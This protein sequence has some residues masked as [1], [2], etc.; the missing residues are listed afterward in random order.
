MRVRC[1]SI[2]YS[3]AQ[4]ERVRVHV[5]SMFALFVILNIIYCS[6]LARYEHTTSGSV[7]RMVVELCSGLL[8]YEILLMSFVHLVVVCMIAITSLLQLLA[9]QRLHAGCSYRCCCCYYRYY[10]YCYCYHRSGCCFLYLY[11]VPFFLNPWL[12]FRTKF[13]ESDRI[14]LDRQKKTFLTIAID[15]EADAWACGCLQKATEPSELPNCL[16][17]CQQNADNRGIEFVEKWLSTITR[18]RIL[19]PSQQHDIRSATSTA[20]QQ[21]SKRNVMCLVAI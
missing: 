6:I 2:L 15:N 8:A 19:F 21:N 4:Y 10:S 12:I 16:A 20:C 7:R 13:V 1:A 3:C 5:S 14:G 11:G 18:T 17:S 9:T